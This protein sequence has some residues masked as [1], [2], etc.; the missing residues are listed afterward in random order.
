MGMYRVLLKSMGLKGSGCDA[1][2]DGAAVKARYG[3]Q[4]KNLACGNLTDRAI[5]HNRSGQTR[6]SFTGQLAILS[7]LS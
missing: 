1:T 3:K 4:N 5:Q 7:K 6:G 2:H